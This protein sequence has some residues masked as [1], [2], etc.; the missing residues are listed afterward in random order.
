MYS[1]TDIPYKTSEESN[2]QSFPGATHFWTPSNVT[3]PFQME[4]T[5]QNDSPCIYFTSPEG[6]PL[7][8][9]TTPLLT[10]TQFNPL[11]LSNSSV[12]TIQLF[13]T[14]TG[15]LAPSE[16]YDGIYNLMDKSPT[17]SL[18]SFERSTARITGDSFSDPKKKTNKISKSLERK[19]EKR[20]KNWSCSHKKH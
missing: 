12:P 20:I 5:N 4:N 1:C 14:A 16:S 17:I 13:P 8:P 7:L 3:V 9:C 18:P 10:Q 19:T 2:T 11:N 6:N 15:G